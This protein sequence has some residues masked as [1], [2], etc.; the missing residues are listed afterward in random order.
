MTLDGRRLHYF[1]TVAEAGSLGRAAALLHVAQPALAAADLIANAEIGK[2]PCK[3]EVQACPRWTVAQQ[4]ELDKATHDGL[5]QPSNW[6]DR[7]YAFMLPEEAAYD[8]GVSGSKAIYMLDEFGAV[9][10][11]FLLPKRGRAKKRVA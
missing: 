9:A 4:T 3:N 1:V 8:H 2:F 7:E 5:W 10:T 6:M 11:P